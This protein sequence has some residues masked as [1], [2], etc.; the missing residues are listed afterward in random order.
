MA[1]SECKR[2]VMGVQKISGPA[3]H[4][5]AFM[6]SWLPAPVEEIP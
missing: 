2:R 4:A 5:H 6:A 1:F 3:G